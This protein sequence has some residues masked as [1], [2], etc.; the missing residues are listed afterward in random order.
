M[1]SIFKVTINAK[2]IMFIEDAEE[3]EIYGKK[4]S[5]AEVLIA[6]STKACILTVWGENIKE[7]KVN[8]S[9]NFANVSTRKFNEE[10]K[11]TT[12]PR[13]TINNIAPLENVVEDKSISLKKFS[14]F[15]GLILAVSILVTKKCSCCF[16]TIPETEIGKTITKCIH[17]SMKQ[18]TS[19]L[20]T[21]IQA[22]INFQCE[23]TTTRLTLFE[24]PLKVFLT[25]RNQTQL[26]QTPEDLEDYL[27]SQQQLKL[28]CNN[29]VIQ[30]I[31]PM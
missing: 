15:V 30:E 23:S 4:T 22:R 19:S 25:K 18:K 9:Y 31:S 5:K 21:T 7:I 28:L 26:L 20:S 2:V 14:E 8:E 10:I 1:I 29:D 12:T 13:T 6:D 17:C 16:K 3:I 24:G 27:L 11:V